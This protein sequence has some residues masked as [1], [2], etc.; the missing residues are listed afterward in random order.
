[1]NHNFKLNDIS[2]EQKCSSII[3]GNYCPRK[4]IY[5][6][7]EDDFNQSFDNRVLESFIE[8]IDGGDNFADYC[9]YIFEILEEEGYYD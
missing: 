6:L 3:K 1:M 2:S 5:Y 9:E 4:D 7:T 8:D